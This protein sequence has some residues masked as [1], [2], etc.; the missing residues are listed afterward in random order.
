MFSAPGT[1][2]ADCGSDRDCGPVVSCRGGKCANAANDTCGSDRD[3]GA[4]SCR[5]GKCSSQGR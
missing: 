5:A 2:R 3:C 1:L 4:G